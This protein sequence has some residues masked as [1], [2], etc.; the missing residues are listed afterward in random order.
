MTMNDGIK[1]LKNKL[2]PRDIPWLALKSILKVREF[3]NA[4]YQPH[5]FYLVDPLLHLDACIRHLMEVYISESQGK[6]IEIKNEES[7][8]MHLEHALCDLAGVVE[9]LLREGTV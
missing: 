3:G 6:G 2:C 9:I 5:T 1:I 4:K 8:L 7:G